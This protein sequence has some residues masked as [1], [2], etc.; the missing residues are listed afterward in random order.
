HRA[1]WHG[2]TGDP[3]APVVDPGLAEISVDEVLTT[4]GEVAEL[5]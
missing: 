4:L 1:I 3:H 2:R 5:A